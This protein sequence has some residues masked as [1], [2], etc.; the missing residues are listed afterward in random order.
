MNTPIVPPLSKHCTRCN[1]DLPASREY[2]HADKSKRDGLNLYCKDCMKAYGDKRKQANPE[3]F[4]EYSRTQGKAY[5]NSEKGKRL[6]KERVKNNREKVMASQQKWRVN[7]PEMARAINLRAV[8]RR[9]GAEGRHNGRDIIEL[10]DMQDRRCGYC[11]MPI[12]GLDYQVDHIVPLSRGGSDW[13]E[14]L[15]IACQTCNG[16]KAT[17]TLEE[18]MKIRGW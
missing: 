3:Y 9:A 14:N 16:N 17:K 4:R 15:L 10:Y 11:G 1:R 8:A 18:W 5:R 13:P 7:N 2:F 12:I 6:A